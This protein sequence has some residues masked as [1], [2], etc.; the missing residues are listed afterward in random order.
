[1]IVG[2]RPIDQEATEEA[3]KECDWKSVAAVMEG[4]TPEGVSYRWL[5]RGLAGGRVES[6]RG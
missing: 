5:R 3:V 1:L 4:L 6:E 2:A